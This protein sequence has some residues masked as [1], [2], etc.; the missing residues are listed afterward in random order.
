[1]SLYS[2]VPDIGWGAFSVSTHAQDGPVAPG[3]QPNA[4]AMGEGPSGQA[5]L[6]TY[7]VTLDSSLDLFVPLQPHLHTVSV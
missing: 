2:Y 3:G 4:V 6:W 7:S 5:R 1:M